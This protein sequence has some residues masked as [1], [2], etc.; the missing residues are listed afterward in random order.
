MVNVCTFVR[1]YAK[2]KLE[3]IHM[4]WNLAA[5][6]GGDV[7]ENESSQKSWSGESVE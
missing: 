2:C 3:I 6:H 5:L 7:A 4:H 1:L